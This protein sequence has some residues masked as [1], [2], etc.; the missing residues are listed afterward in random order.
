MAEEKSVQ[1]SSSDKASTAKTV[2]QPNTKKQ[3]AG[4]KL[5]PLLIADQEP[6]DMRGVKAN[7]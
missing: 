6:P 4:I 2:T 7:A 5:F 3:S 1:K